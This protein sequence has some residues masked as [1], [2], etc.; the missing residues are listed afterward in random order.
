MKTILIIAALFCVATISNAQTVGTRI[1]GNSTLTNKLVVSKGGNGA[2]KLFS[3]LG[4]N[5]SGSTA[6]V[7]VFNATNTPANGTIPT[8][9]IPVS[10]APQYYSLDFGYYGADFD[11][12]TV[13]IS[14]NA[15]TLGLAST[16]FTI[17][18]VL[19]GN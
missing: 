18:A 8:F 16:N 10:A 9:S 6:Y 12:I 4:Q 2:V 3:V 13:C 15:T 1:V 7:Q 5:V 11:H 14:T 17:Q 19:R